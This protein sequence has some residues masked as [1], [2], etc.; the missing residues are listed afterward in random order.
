[1]PVTVFDPGTYCG[2]SGCQGH[3]SNEQR[4]EFV[5]WHQ[6]NDGRLQREALAAQERRRIQREEEEARLNSSFTCAECDGEDIVRNSLTVGTSGDIVCTSCARPCSVCATP[7]LREEINTIT[8]SWGSTQYLCDDCTYSCDECGDQMARGEMYTIGGCYYCSACSRNCEYCE[9]RI[10]S[11]CENDGCTN[12]VRGLSSYGKTHANRWLGGPVRRSAVEKDKGYYLGFE[13]EITANTG[14]VQPVYDWAETHLGYVDAVDCKEDS[15]VEG[16]EIATQ[17]MTP[18]FFESVNW[19]SF[20]D[21]L[22]EEF[23]MSS[24]SRGVEPVDHGLHVHIGRVAFDKDDIAMAA[25]CYL[26]GQGDHLVRVARREPTTYCKKVD[27]P[28]S[29]AIRSEYQRMGTHRMQANKPVTRGLYL[30]RDAIN[31]GNSSTI[32][33]RAFRSTRK[34]D[35]LRDAMRLVYVAAEYIRSLRAGKGSVSPKA[36]HWATFAAWVGVNH[37]DAF[38]SIAGITDKK[39]V[40]G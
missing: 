22:N 37:P 8:R 38:A 35:D 2:C 15:S 27:K 21:M 33:I 20:F 10:V 30:G 23:P 16:F 19:E 12:R 14:N 13:L 25:F 7:V 4:A 39:V 6:E 9:E 28:V 36:L 32:E 1:M 3:L 40:K 26:I 18:A 17:P 31:L 29:S 5:A 11:E 24:R 34:A